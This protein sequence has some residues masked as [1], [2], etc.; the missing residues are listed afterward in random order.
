[1]VT[2]IYILADS[3]MI[4]KGIGELAIAALNIILPLFNIMF[5]TGALFGI[6]GAVLFSVAMGNGDP[7]RAKR[8]FTIATL[9]TTLFV[10]FYLFCGNLFLE[11]I[12]TFLGATSLTWDYAYDYTKWLM[13]GT[14]VFAFS[15]LL[16]SFVRNDKNPKLAMTAVITGGVLNTLLDWIFIYPM[17]LGMTGAIVASIIGTGV[18]CLILC[19]HFFRKDCNLRFTKK[20]LRTR[21][22]IEVFQ[23]GFSSFLTEIS[24][25]VLIFVLNQQALLYAGELGVTTYSVLTNSAYIVNAF[26]NGIAQAAQPIIATNFGAKLHDRIQAIK[27][28]GIRTALL[29]GS[30]FAIIGLCFPSAVV[31]FFIHPTDAILQM[32]PL[33]VQIYFVSF[34]GAAVNIFFTSYFQAILQPSKALTICMLR[35]L[36]L[37]V[38]FAYTLPMVLG[39]NG[40]WMSILLAEAITL[41]IAVLLNRK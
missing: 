32:A 37:S 18:T 10:V 33:A 5:G 16:Q 23:Y 13:W 31:Y 27:A 39:I 21:Y 29:E 25:G 41:L 28:I 4:G 8:Y 15:M 22:G 38:V 19:V 1:M 40:I 24:G 9:L 34:I 26:S 3:I 20:R 36:I 30:I 14:P 12:L 35:G 6:G 17:Q 11:E 2:S 7:E